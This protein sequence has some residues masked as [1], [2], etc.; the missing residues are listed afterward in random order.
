[1]SKGLWVLWL[2]VLCVYRR[3]TPTHGGVGPT[4][5]P[6]IIHTKYGDLQ[7]VYRHL[8]NKNLEPVE[9]YLGVP[10][11]SP[12][13]GTLRFMP[14]VTPSLWNDVRRSDHFKPVCP[15]KFPDISNETECLSRMP[16]ARYDHLK[17]FQPLLKN[18]SEDCL[19]LNIYVPAKGNS[20]YYNT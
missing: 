15:Q 11:A 8:P 3:L 1:M 10:Y 18:Y 2:L 6:R 9:V 5:S 14:P 16:R 19:Y 12:P 17:R 13:V 7:G 4:P 20:F